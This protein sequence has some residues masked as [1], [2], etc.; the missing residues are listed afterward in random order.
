MM[1][2]R[3][4]APPLMTVDEFLVHDFPDGRAELVR[5]EPRVNPPAGGPHALI[6]TNLL[7]LLMRH[8]DDYGLGLVFGDGAGFELR[9]L[10]HTVRAPD[11]SFIRSDR[12][13]A[14]G[15]GPGFLRMAPDLAVEIL[16]P[17][18]TSRDSRKSSRTTARLE[19]RSC[20]SSIQTGKPYEY[21]RWMRLCVC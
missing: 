2:Q 1:A 20:G 7:R 4:G 13:P 15:I 11:V 5:G 17:S 10:P 21:T 18:E 12:I 19:R 16:S 9:A 6:A 8:V 3:S 14:N